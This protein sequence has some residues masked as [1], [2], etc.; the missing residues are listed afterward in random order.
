M[1][2]HTRISDIGQNRC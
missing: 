1:G 2:I